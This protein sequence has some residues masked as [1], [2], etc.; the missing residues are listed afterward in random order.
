[1]YCIALYR[2][3]NK[4]DRNIHTLYGLIQGAQ[5]IRHIYTHIIWSHTGGKTNRINLYTHCIASYRGQNK[6]DES[7]L[8]VFSLKTNRI[9]IYTLCMASYRGMNK[10]DRYIHTHIVSS[11]TGG[12]TNQAEIYTHCM[13][14]YRVQYKSDIYIHTFYGL[15]QGEEQIR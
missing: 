11:Y 1:M 9:N 4:S 12:P 3:P 13:A 15:I 5:Q 7:I 2:G 8:S 6:L 14:L 10:S